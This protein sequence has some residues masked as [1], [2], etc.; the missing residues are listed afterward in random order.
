MSKESTSVRMILSWPV[1]Y[2]ES[3]PVVSALQGLMLA[4]RS[5]PGCVGC[6]LSTDAHKR[7]AVTIRYVEEWNSEAELTQQLR[8][9]RFSS[10]AELMEHASEYPTIEFL[11]PGATRGIDYADEVRG[12]GTL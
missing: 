10:L 3:G 4:T 2:G 1:P 7:T 6:W 9:D 11:L 12:S 5:E 8:S